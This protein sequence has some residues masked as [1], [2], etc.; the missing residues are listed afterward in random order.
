MKMALK[1]KLNEEGHLYKRV[2]GRFL[3]VPKRGLH[4][5]ILEEVHNSHGHFGVHA[6]WARLYGTY[7]WPGCY[8]NVKMFLKSCHKF[9]LYCIFHNIPTIIANNEVPITR[10]FQRFSIDF[11]GPFPLSSTWN[12]Y[13]IIVGV[14]DFTRWPFAKA[15]KAATAE[16][17]ANFLY[18]EIFTFTGPF[19]FVL[20]DNGSHFINEVVEQFLAFVRTHHLYSTPYHP[21][22]SGRIKI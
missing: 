7:W 2:Q 11:V 4:L 22:T 13:I 10:L 15:M 21:Q 1:Y 19:D 6:T 16:V 20:S 18:K 9:Q 8:D 12:K 5:K 14:E 17:A 3:M